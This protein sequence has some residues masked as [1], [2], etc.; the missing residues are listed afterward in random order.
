MDLQRANSDVIE[1]SFNDSLKNGD[2]SFLLDTD[3]LKLEEVVRLR[4]AHLHTFLSGWCIFIKAAFLFFLWRCIRTALFWMMPHM[5][6][7]ADTLL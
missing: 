6:F 7:F 4:S 1:K 3:E 2:S 5:R